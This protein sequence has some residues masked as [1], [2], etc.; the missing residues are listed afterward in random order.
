MKWYKFSPEKK[1]SQKLPPIKKDVLVFLESRE[2]GLPSSIAVGYRKNA[3]G[4]KDCP[5]FVI[6][7]LGGN[8]L[9]WCDCLPDE[10]D[11]PSEY[12]EC[13]KLIELS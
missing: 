7:G 2:K 5:Y 13:E 11:L 1:S 4:D 10:F 12:R 6:P 3:A 8:V 9:A